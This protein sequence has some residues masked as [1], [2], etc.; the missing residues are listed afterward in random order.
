M[1]SSE[2]FETQRRNSGKN[3][4]NVVVDVFDAVNVRHYRSV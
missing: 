2:N 1:Y 4:R 3:G